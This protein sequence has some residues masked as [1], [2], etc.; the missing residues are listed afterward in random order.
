MT[1]MTPIAPDTAQANP[2]AAHDEE[3]RAAQTNA[4]ARMTDRLEIAP[5]TTLSATNATGHVG[6][7]LACT[8]TQGPY[9]VVMDLGPAMGGKAEG[10][11]PSF[12]ARAAIAGCVAIATKMTAVREGLRFD[13]VNVDVD[14]CFDNAALFGLGPNSAAPLT[15]RVQ[16]TIETEEDEEVVNALIARVLE[17]DPWYLALRDA[18]KVETMTTIAR[19]A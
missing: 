3:I 16:L 17:Q 1:L 15:T 6:E 9:S 8:V 18:Q 4:Y 13:S 12:Y 2:I 5:E 10:P 11:S 19:K 7:G 14:T